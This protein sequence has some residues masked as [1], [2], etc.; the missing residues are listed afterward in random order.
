MGDDGMK[1]VNII[2]ILSMV[3][4][5]CTIHVV[6]GKKQPTTVGF[7]KNSIY[8]D[9]TTDHAITVY[10]THPNFCGTTNMIKELKTAQRRL[11]R[12]H[13]NDSKWLKRNLSSKIQSTISPT[14]SIKT[15]GT[16]LVSER[17][18]EIAAID[19]YLSSASKRLKAIVSG[20]AELT[21]VIKRLKKESA[22]QQAQRTVG[23]G[24]PN[25][26][27]ISFKVPK[28]KTAGANPFPKRWVSLRG[29]LGR[30]FKVV[31]WDP[32]SKREYSARYVKRGKT[33]KYPH[34]MKRKV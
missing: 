26:T 17:E 27:C 6:Y 12:V 3:A 15:T 5:S 22:K 18:R 19:S 24:E 14:I 25:N 2:I 33:I 9:N 21:A 11:T 32:V 4:S 8:V 30:S 20:Q 13:Q 16:A 23:K 7:D 31:T 10:L 1:I 29:W 28:G 34:D